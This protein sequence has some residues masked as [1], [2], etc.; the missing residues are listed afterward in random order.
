MYDFKLLNQMTVLI[1][2]DNLPLLEIFEQNMQ[3]IFH[4]VFTATNAE[5]ALMLYEKYKP[6]IIF[7]DINLP[8]SN[9]IELVEKIRKKDDQTKVIVVTSHTDTE[10]L[11]SAVTLKLED[12]VVKPFDFKRIRDLLQNYEESLMSKEVMYECEPDIRIDAVNNR[13]YK[14]GKEV[15]L[16]KTEKIIFAFL[17]KNKNHILDYET[18]E[19]YIWAGD[20]MSKG[21]LKTLIYKLRQKMGTDDVIINH[22]GIGYEI[23]L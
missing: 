21:S 19:D 11:L 5:D 1:V 23:R 7:T 13:V 3:R 12:Y 8:G 16:T 15:K 4:K 17:I 14:A 22:K 18:I 20:P 2:E 6:A 9:G 10:Y